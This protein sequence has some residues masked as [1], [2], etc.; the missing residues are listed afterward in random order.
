[1]HIYQDQAKVLKTFFVFMRKVQMISEIKKI[2]DLTPQLTS[3]LPPTRWQISEARAAAVYSKR[4][5]KTNQLNFVQ[6]ARRLMVPI[7][8]RYE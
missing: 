2:N 7:S 4:L 3:H 6:A 5:H 8:K 1:M